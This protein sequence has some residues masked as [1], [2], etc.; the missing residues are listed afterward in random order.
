[1][2]YRI[3]FCDDARQHLRGLTA[4]QRSLVLDSSSEQLVH[5]PTVPTRNRKELLPNFLARWE[6]RVRDLRV[7][8]IVFEEPDPVVSIRAIGTKVGSKVIIQGEEVEL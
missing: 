1:L 3:E 6:L 8:Y 2:P 4:A 7:F 5:Q